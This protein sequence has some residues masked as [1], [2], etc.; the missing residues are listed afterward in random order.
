MK[1]QW[2]FRRAF[3][4]SGLACRCIF[5]EIGMARSTEALIG[6]EPPSVSFDF[7]IF[8]EFGTLNDSRTK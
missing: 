7:S 2:R 5:D 1:W 6:L 8:Y 4:R 3:R